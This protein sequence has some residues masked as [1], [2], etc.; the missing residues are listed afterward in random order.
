M[1][2]VSLSALDLMQHRLPG[3]A[4]AVGSLAEREIP[5]RDVG[6]E[7]GSDLVGQPDPPRRACRDLL[8]GEQPFAQ[9][10]VDSRGRHVE[11]VGGLFDRDRVAVRLGLGCDLD[12]RALTDPLDAGRAEREVGPG[13]PSPWR[14]RIAAICWSG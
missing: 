2:R 13:A 7:P 6:H 12:A 11:C 5:V 9:P 1:H 14:L 4:E 8:A 3:N 10:P